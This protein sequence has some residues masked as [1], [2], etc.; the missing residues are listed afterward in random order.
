MLDERY[1]VSS[2]TM[3]PSIEARRY[4]TDNNSA[5]NSRGRD[6]RRWRSGGKPRN[7][8]AERQRY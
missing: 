1:G 2:S 4:E 5:G 8:M 3:I 6:G 7:E